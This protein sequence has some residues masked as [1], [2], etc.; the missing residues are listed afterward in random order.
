MAR[1]TFK[2]IST[3]SLWER[4]TPVISIFFLITNYFCP[5]LFVFFS[6]VCLIVFFLEV[7]MVCLNVRDF[8]TSKTLKTH[9]VAKYSSSITRKTHLFYYI[10]HYA[11]FYM[12][13]L[14]RVIRK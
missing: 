13:L 7:K 14:P 6:F 5:A 2:L 1:T 11:I 4:R 8:E 10:L 3:C 9:K 12:Y